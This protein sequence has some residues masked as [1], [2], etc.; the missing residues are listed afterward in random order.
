MYTPQTV[1]GYSHEMHYNQ[2]AILETIFRHGY[3]STQN[4]YLTNH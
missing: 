2:H 1:L 3:A 4:G